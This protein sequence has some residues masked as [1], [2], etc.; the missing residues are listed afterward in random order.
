MWLQKV[1][2]K[3]EDN[4]KDFIM[5]V[6]ISSY[7]EMMDKGFKYYDFSGQEV[8]IID[9][10]VESGVNYGRLRIWNQ[11]ELVKEAN[12]YCSLEYTRRM[13]YEI[14][15]RGMGLLLDFHYSDWWA[16]PGQQNKPKAWEGL[17]MSELTEA[18]YQY[19]RTVLQKLN[20]DGNY[21]DMVQVGNEIRC[22]M[23]WPEGDTKDWG[24]LA[25]LINAGI[26]AVRD[27]QGKRDTKVMLHLDQGGKYYYYKNWFDH[28]MKE[29][30][31]DFDIIG[32]SYYPF[33]HGTYYDLKNTM[34]ELVKR[35]KKPLIL[36][37]IAY[38][39]QTKEDGFFKKD[40]E[41]VG[42]FPATPQNQRTAL[43]LIMNITAG[44]SK[45]KGLGVFYWEPFDRAEPGK[46]CWGTC[47]GIVDEDGRPT[48][49]FRALSFNAANMKNDEIIK[50]YGP[51]MIKVKNIEEIKDKLPSKIKALCWDGTLTECEV[52]WSLEDLTTDS[53]M[54]VCGKL[55]AT[56]VGVTLQVIVTGDNEER[57]LLPENADFPLAIKK[58]EGEVLT[59][60]RKDEESFFYFE[61]DE[62]FF[63]ELTSG[64]ELEPGEYTFEV[65]YMG[66]NTTGVEVT[67]FAKGAHA[68]G[69]KAIYP[70]DNEWVL[71]ELKFEV[72][73]KEE[74]VL[75]IE[76]KAPAI[77]G[78]IRRPRLK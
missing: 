56:G 41:K 42:G 49:G 15:K 74:L 2:R 21:P 71:H 18:V 60:I 20:D 76:I 43:E 53:Q 39:Y 47:M 34:E 36:A 48:E 5:G 4:M 51:E 38:A 61:A 29:G 59:E 68:K 6:D 58:K 70:S 75:G 26:R 77:Y 12:G 3:R 50:T 22:G 11:P 27:T 78:K 35:Y 63:L 57:N 44:V 14:K 7:P 72:L 69:E 23:I 62:N 40:Q 64:C 73:Q 19:T 33:W 8:N 65:E 55:Q 54:T 16:D 28:V 31:W 46:G 67:L 52:Q 32:L 9:F 24:K 66:T 1:N 17:S 25:R 10:A 30:V 13:A 37:E 45:G